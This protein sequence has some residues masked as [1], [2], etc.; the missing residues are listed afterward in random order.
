MF[1][2]LGRALLKELLLGELVIVARSLLRMLCVY[3]GYGTLVIIHTLAEE[4]G[5]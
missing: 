5:V 1:T 2:D 4:A 3:Y